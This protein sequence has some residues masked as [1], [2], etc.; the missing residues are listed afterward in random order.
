MRCKALW[1]I[2]EVLQTHEL[3]IYMGQN[4]IDFNDNAHPVKETLDYSETQFSLLNNQTF[5]SEVTLNRVDLTDNQFNP[6]DTETHYF[7]DHSKINTILH[8]HDSSY[9]RMDIELFSITYGLGIKGNHYKRDQFNVWGLMSELG[10]FMFMIHF[11]ASFFIKF[12]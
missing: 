6:L 9:E 7:T 5:Y 10:G 2:D 3:R 4:Y 1:Q 8:D 12:F 11:L